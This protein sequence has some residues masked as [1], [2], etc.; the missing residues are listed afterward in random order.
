MG[1]EA[2]REIGQGTGRGLGI[3]VE[4][5]WVYSPTLMLTACIINYWNVTQN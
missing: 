5:T 3:Q 2:E 1:K 4:K